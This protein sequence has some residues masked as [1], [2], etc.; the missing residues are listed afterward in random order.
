MRV[1][2]AAYAKWSGKRALKGSRDRAYAALLIFEPDHKRARRTLKYRW[3]KK[4]GSWLRPGAYTRP[5]D[6][7]GPVLEEATA[8]WRDLTELHAHNVFK[9]LEGVQGPRRARAIDELLRVAPDNFAAHKEHGELRVGDKWVLIETTTAPE[10]RAEIEQAAKQALARAPKPRAVDLNGEDRKFGVA[11]PG[12]W[13]GRTWRGMGNVPQEEVKR[14][15]RVADAT[16]PLFDA[17]FGGRSRTGVELTFY[18]L[19]GGKG[20]GKQALRKHPA[21]GDAERRFVQGLSGSW[22]P[23]SFGFITWG[24]NSARRTD[25]VARQATGMY[26]RSRFGI[27]GTQG[28]L[29]EGIGLYF[30]YLLTGTRLTTSAKRTGYQQDPLAHE[31]QK[32]GVEFAKADWVELARRLFQQERPPDLRLIV[33]KDVNTLT[34][35]DLLVCYAMTS[36]LLE[37]RPEETVNFLAAYGKG[38]NLDDALAAYLDVDLAGFEKRLRRWMEERS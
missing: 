33:A 36:Y 20:A 26:L 6:K 35:N 28:W 22:V 13:K 34:A 17:V 5:E 31:Q 27:T 30:T 10:R 32:R 14:T 4:T 18:L 11:F 25:I 24:E 23:E 37:C 15:L 12:A 9:A 16:R 19:K 2:L 8:R 29:Y 38:D 1:E 7:P 21:Y 3:N